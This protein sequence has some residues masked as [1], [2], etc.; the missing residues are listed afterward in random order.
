MSIQMR[1]LELIGFEANL[2]K[3]LEI[4]LVNSDM[5][6]ANK[7]ILKNTFHNNDRLRAE[8]CEV[9]EETYTPEE[10]QALVEFYESPLGRKCTEMMPVLFQKG[11]DIGMKYGRIAE[12][13]F[14]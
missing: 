6:D 8:M 11:N 13:K 14:V 12:S 1:L 9:I 7:E 2:Q 10:C 5:S 4:A 3:G